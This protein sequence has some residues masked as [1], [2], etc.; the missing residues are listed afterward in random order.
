M[1]IPAMAVLSQE[2]EVLTADR[3]GP[4]E[5]GG[6]HGFGGGRGVVLSTRRGCDRYSRWAGERPGEGL[7]TN[8]FLC[9]RDVDGP[10]IHTVGP[11]EGN[12]QAGHARVPGSGGGGDALKGDLGLAT[13]G[14]RH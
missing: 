7:G 5:G 3:L 6:G 13:R 11:S 12:D 1:I 2:A 9:G 14:G 10:A 8:F 4:V